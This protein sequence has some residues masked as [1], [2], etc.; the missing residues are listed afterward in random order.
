MKVINLSESRPPLYPTT[1]DRRQAL[2]LV[3]PLSTVNNP[4]KYFHIT[5]EVDCEMG[6]AE[7]RAL[8]DKKEPIA[9]ITA[10]DY[11][12]GLIAEKGGAEWILVGDSL[13][14]TC[15]G[16]DSTSHVTLDEMIHHCKAVRRAVKKAILVGDLPM[17]SFEVS[18]EQALQSSIRLVKEGR[19]DCVKLEG[20]AE[21]APHVRKITQSGIA[22]S[23]HIGMM[24]QRAASLGGLRTYGSTVDEA[25]TVL[26]DALALQE[27]G[28][29]CVVLELVPEP[30]AKII[31]E[32]LHIPTVG[33][34]SGVG[35]SVQVLLQTDVTGLGVPAFGD[36][37]KKYGN[38]MDQ[39]ISAIQQFKTEVQQR[40]FPNRSNTQIPDAPKDVVDK[41][42]QVAASYQRK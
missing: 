34:G 18:P 36:Y 42:R 9:A 16:Y 19:A 3:I 7:F 24:L 32:T 33:I 31:T 21:M 5:K 20:G 30:I 37:S 29:F 40:K 25:E 27:A 10:Y 14:V 1:I 4:S 23:G 12:T 28:A 15:L 17:G 38:L 41:F 8:Y 2:Y 22:V 11:P 39:G 13:A 26:K 6:F 35:C